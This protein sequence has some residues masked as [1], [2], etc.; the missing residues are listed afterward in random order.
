[1]GFALL[2]VSAWGRDVMRND[3]YTVTGNPD[4]T[5]TIETAGVP[6]Q[7]LTPAFTVMFSA[8]NPG[9]D[10]NH[11][12]YLL[13]PRTS[14][15]WRAYEESEESLNAFLN[16]SAVRADLLY[17]VTVSGSG[18][19][20]VWTWHADASRRAVK[21]KVAG[22]YARGTLNPF[23]A[24]RR[25]DL[26]ASGA[27]ISAGKIEWVFDDNPARPFTLVAG[28]ELPPG[29]A[30][31]RITLRFKAR[32]AGY[33]AAAFTG[34]PALPVTRAGR[35]E[36]ETATAGFR[37]FNH[38]VGEGTLHL[39]HVYLSSKDGWTA[40]LALDRANMPFSAPATGKPRVPY[41]ADAYCGAMLRKDYENGVFQPVIFAPLMGGADSKMK[42]G[43]ARATT[44]HYVLRAGDWKGVYRR[45]AQRLYGNTDPRDNTGTGSLN[46]TLERIVDFLANRNGQNYAMWHDEQKY[47][48]YANDLPGSFKPFSPLFGLSL[49]LAFDDEDFYRAR[50]RPQVEFALSRN[51]NYFAP[52]D[53]E[54]DTAMISVVNRRLGTPYLGYTQLVSLH[55]M[56]QNRNHALLHYVGEKGAARAVFPE[57]LAKYSVTK[58]P[59]DL[60]AALRDAKADLAAEP[61]GTRDHFMDWLDIWEASGETPATRDP[62][63]L[64]AAAERA[65]GKV[66][67]TFTLAP[68]V[69]DADATFDKG[70]FAPVHA[71]SVG[72]HIRWGFPKPL[73]YPTP[74]QTVPAWRG[75]L[76][77][78]QGLGP[79][80]AEFWMDNHAHL[81]RIGALTGDDFLRAIARWGM[82]GRFAHYPGDNRS[83]VSLLVERPG[84]AENPLWK[85]THATFNPG[86]AWEF[87]AA[88]LDFLVADVFACSQSAIDFPSR[89]MHGAQFRVRL[90]GDR[91]GRFYN[92]TGIRLWMPKSLAAASSPHIDYISGYGNG[93]LYFAFVNQAAAAPSSFSTPSPSCG[94]TPS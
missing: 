4:L 26:K 10:E 37:L 73:G 71:H 3:L 6:A 23:L 14:L 57:L 61:S 27:R 60:D 52:Y 72:R 53:I 56:Y 32:K 85:M 1:M 91:P 75:A 76:N 39:P 29:D 16:S 28:L 70:G 48:D 81:M 9:L 90:Y 33:F 12:N 2:A 54:K 92:E 87:G 51:T 88:V 89:S 49:A 15:L 68:A 34:A 21:L 31:P 18:D 93:N 25:H 46:R 24:G 42:P 22:R 5:V 84:L 50:V 38:V 8:A 19:K 30:D 44:V 45:I 64:N 20:R 86:H 41:R 17:P 82:V 47:Y 59:A 69:P 40:A 43:D 67:S 55:G 80:R 13:A 58:A 62:S 83:A 65:Y 35:V 66:I 79:Y 77:G 94:S 63:F 74:E 78:L 36:Q 11:S 7:T